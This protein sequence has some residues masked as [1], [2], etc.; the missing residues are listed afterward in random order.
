ML[1][2]SFFLGGFECSSHRRADGRR[3]DLLAATGH[4]A[5]AMSDYEQLA[6]LGIR[7]V[8]DGLRWHLF[9]SEPGRY[10]F[11]SVDTMLE[12]ASRTGMQVVWDLCH[13]GHPDHLDIWRPSFVDAFAQFAQ[14]AALHVSKSLDTTPMFCA[15]NEISYWAWAGGD[16][17]MMNP[18]DV[19]RGL[20]LKHQLARAAMAGTR[21]VLAA[22]PHA[23]MVSV[24]PLIALWPADDESILP[25]RQFEEAQLDGWKLVSGD[26]WP[27]LGGEP[28]LLDIIGVNYYPDNQWEMG[29]LTP[30]RTIRVGDPRYRSL[31]ELLQDM[32]ARFARPLLIAETG[33]EDDERVPWFEYVCDEAAAALAGGVPILGICLYPIADYPGWIDE[34]HCL[35]GLVG[36]TDALGRREVHADFAAA[37]AR[38]QRRFD[39]LLHALQ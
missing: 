35:T 3:L 31:R 37:L 20:E 14:A 36:P 38:Q 22:V 23:R 16:R 8:R 4:A 11:T 5:H 2:N 15:V 39:Q 7:S 17:A 6:S 27:G 24:D 1:F 10:D 21:A 19:G 9:E 34:R 29:G 30:G 25:A 13:Y 33:A 28:S 26:L 12:A 18:L 32:H